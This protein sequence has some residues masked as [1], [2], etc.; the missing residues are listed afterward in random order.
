MARPSA[1]ETH[2]AGALSE[3]DER[4]D[5][6][7][8]P[9][10]A[11]QPQAATAGHTTSAAAAAATAPRSAGSSPA[12]S[13][14]APLAALA[15]VGAAGA[16]LLRHFLRRRKEGGCERVRPPTVAP[17]QVFTSVRALEPPAAAAAGPLDGRTLVLSECLDVAGLETRF[18]CTPWSAGRRPADA[19][20]AP[21]QALVA[22]A[23]RGRGTV[24][25]E[26]LGLG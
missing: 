2:P 21:A 8:A 12:R 25:S 5:Q 14:A 4:D 9:A 11:S 17:D 13:V 20:F 1:A 22:A 24:L 19:T 3:D 18:G 10:A 23:A 16:L 6:H 26:P 7:D 15:A